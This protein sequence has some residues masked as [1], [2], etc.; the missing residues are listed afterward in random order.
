[1]RFF[2]A[3]RTEGKLYGYRSLREGRVLHYAPTLKEYTCIQYTQSRGHL[4]M[5]QKGF[6]GLTALKND[7][8]PT[9]R[10]DWQW[11]TRKNEYHPR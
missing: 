5:Y 11:Y 3:L 6:V 7:A 8:L 2:N 4:Y 10:W 1:M 9:C